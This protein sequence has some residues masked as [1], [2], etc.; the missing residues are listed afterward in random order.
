[1][2]SFN[3]IISLLLLFSCTAPKEKNIEGSTLTGYTQG[4]TY[5]II[6]AEEKI[7]F[8]Q[9]EIDQLLAAFDTILS[10]YIPKSEISKLNN[11]EHQHSFSDKHGFFKTCYQLS[12]QIY[13]E[14]KGLFDPSIYPLVKS[15]GFYNKA[16]I[17]PTQHQIDSLLEFISFE[18]EKLH[19]V[20]FKGDSV[21]FTKKDARFKL[22]FNAIAQGYSVDVVADFIQSRG[23]KNFY[24]EIGGEVRVAGKNRSAEK[25]NLGIDV[26]D[27]LEER[28]SLTS[29]AITNCGIATSGNYRNYFEKDG[30][31][32]GHI[33]SPKN[34]LPGI[35]DVL[36][37]T[38]IHRNA[39]LA[40]AYA[41]VFMLIGKNESIAF[42]KNNPDVK[43]LLVYLDKENNMQVYKT[44]NFK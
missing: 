13:V 40:D 12:Q 34:G 7:N 29:I 9:Q 3:V 1:M 36:S 2:R 30:K 14:S 25:W 32:Y 27:E 18:P 35:T 28:E 31:K 24:V 43:L 19:T 38:V 8:E 41:T 16:E 21:H 44:P 20:T 6:I 26:P 22:D 11:S 42:C 17:I 33:L 4:T 37:T 10:T 15:W 23:H 39:A 5:S